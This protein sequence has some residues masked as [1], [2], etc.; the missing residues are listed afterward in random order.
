MSAGPQPQPLLTQIPPQESSSCSGTEESH[1]DPMAQPFV[2]GRRRHG[3][4]AGASG[5]RR[6]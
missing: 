6:A 2:L 3:G 4:R 1:G 5:E